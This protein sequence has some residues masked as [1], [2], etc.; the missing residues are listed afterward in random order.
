MLVKQTYIVI[1]EYRYETYGRLA[2]IFETVDG[3]FFYDGSDRMI[4]VRQYQEI[5]SDKANQIIERTRV[6][7]RID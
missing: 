4:E 5:T 2:T 1:D 3:R 6:L 7:L